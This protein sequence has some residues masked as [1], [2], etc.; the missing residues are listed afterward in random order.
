MLIF[1]VTIS[2]PPFILPHY[3]LASGHTTSL[4]H[5]LPVTSLLNAVAILGLHLTKMQRLILLP[6]PFW[7]KL[8]SSLA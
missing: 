6:T 5:V 1:I 4:I 3:S 2:L 8:L 7:L